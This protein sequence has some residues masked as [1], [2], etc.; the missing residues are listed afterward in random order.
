METQKIIN[1]LSD[2]NDEELN[3]LQKMYVID[4]QTAKDKYNQF[5]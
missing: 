1:L 5:Y 2:S 3:L 4:S